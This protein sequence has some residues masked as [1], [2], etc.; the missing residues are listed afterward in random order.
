MHKPIRRN[1]VRRRV[2]VNG[3]DEI[4]RA[5]LVDMQAFSKWNKGIKYILNIID[6]FSKHA[7]CIPLKDKTGT[8]ITE[9]FEKVVKSSKRK[10]QKLWVNQGSEFYNRTLISG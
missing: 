8:S 6:V 9:A 1:F 5:D 2:I 10:P 7:W 4:G 3:I